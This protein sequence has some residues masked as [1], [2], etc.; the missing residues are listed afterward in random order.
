MGQEG[1]SGAGGWAWGRK[2]R[3]E[4]GAGGWEW[5]RRVGVGQEG[6]NGAGGWERGRRV[7]V[8]KEDGRVWQ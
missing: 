6:V 8:W 4:G 5:D 7:G 1:G 2:V 3:K